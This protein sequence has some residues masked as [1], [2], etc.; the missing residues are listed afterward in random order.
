[1]S[2]RVWTQIDVTCGVETADILAAEV[3]EAFGVGVE[4]VSGGIRFYLDSARFAEQERRVRQIVGSIPALPGEGPVG[5]VLSEIPD[6][7]WS[8]AWKEHFKPLSVG[9]R[10]L[11]LPSWEEAP[12]DTGRLLIRINPGRAFGTGHHETTRLCLEWLES[13]GA[14]VAAGSRPCHRV[15]GRGLRVVRHRDVRGHRPPPTALD[16]GTGSGIL[17]I[18]AA[19]LGFQEVVG[20]DNDPEAIEAAGENAMLNGLSER[21]RLL[22]ATPEEIEGSFDVV[23]ANIESKP[24][25]R[26]SE[27]IASKVRVNGLLALSGILAEQSGEVCAEYEKRG[28]ILSGMKTAGE[29]V[30]LAF[31][32]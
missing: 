24:L 30:L 14:G 26:M 31:R 8:S 23:I 17:A 12:R 28:L 19:L 7:D 27:T 22:R 4:Y 9:R 3:V 32:K 20:I 21:I 6:R 11:V 18:G 25:V 15:A 2:T 16:V 13:S 10:F 29:W 5:L 1:M